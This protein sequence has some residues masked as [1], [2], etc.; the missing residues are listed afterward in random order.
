MAD[1]MFLIV[2]IILMY[3]IINET[4]DYLML[5]LLGL[6]F[7][8]LTFDVT[9]QMIAGSYDKLF[10]A[11]IPTGA[12]STQGW[13]ISGIFATIPIFA[14][15]KVIIRR[16]QKKNMNKQIIPADD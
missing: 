6:L 10:T 12:F 3:I 5:L 9:N 14:F 11:S 4:E 8:A 15:V 13:G 2:F 7:T 16:E 1:A